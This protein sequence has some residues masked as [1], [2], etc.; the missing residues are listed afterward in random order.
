MEWLS[1]LVEQLQ[2]EG[3]HLRQWQTMLSKYLEVIKLAF[4]HEDFS[5][6]DIEVFQDLVEECYYLYIEL[7]GLPGVTNY[8]HLLGAGHLYF[9]L[10]KWGNLFCYQQQGWEMKNGVIASFINRRTRRGGAG[11]KYGPA[12]TSRIIPVMEWFQR[13]TAWA[14]GEA[15]LFFS[16]DN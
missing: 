1:V 5:N 16:D 2:L 14:T 15:F 7:L 13:T 6:E 12:H 11:G 3:N 9:Y 8:I 4:Q 10:K